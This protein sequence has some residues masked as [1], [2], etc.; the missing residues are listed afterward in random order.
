MCGAA[1][2]GAVRAQTQEMAHIY[3]GWEAHGAE[4]RQIPVGVEAS[5]A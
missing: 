3:L 1:G 4:L 2:G 5:T